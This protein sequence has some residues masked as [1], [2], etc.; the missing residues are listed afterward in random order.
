[1]LDISLDFSIGFR[2]SIRILKNFFLSQKD[3]EK[4]K[5][6]IFDND[7]VRTRMKLLFFFILRRV[8]KLKE[9]DWRGTGIRFTSKEFRKFLPRIVRLESFEYFDTLYMHGPMEISSRNGIPTSSSQNIRK[10]QL[11]FYHQGLGCHQAQQI[12]LSI[13]SHCN[14][15]Q[16]LSVGLVTPAILDEILN[17]HVSFIIPKVNKGGDLLDSLLILLVD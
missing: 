2:N 5:L 11:P 4:I 10:L 1:M 7:R 16:Y 8:P 9:L 14:S 3:L 15:L 12:C 13:L 6:A 17:V